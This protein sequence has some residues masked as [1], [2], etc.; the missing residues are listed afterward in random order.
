MSKQS[1]CHRVTDSTPSYHRATCCPPFYVSMNV[2]ECILLKL[3]LVR[4]LITTTRK[5]ITDNEQAKLM[6]GDNG[7]S[8]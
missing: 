4:H 5:A 6:G 3:F 1:L 7:V 2:L 8:G